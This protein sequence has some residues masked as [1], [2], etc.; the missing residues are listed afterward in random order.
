M[1]VLIVDD[2]PLARIALAQILTARADVESF[3]AAND[4]IETCPRT[5]S[6]RPV[7]GYGPGAQN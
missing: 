7:A 2:E 5:E 6:S 4:A 3:H 1:R